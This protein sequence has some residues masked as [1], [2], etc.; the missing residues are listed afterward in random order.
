MPTSKR[1]DTIKPCQDDR[2]IKINPSYA[3]NNR[4]IAYK[5]KGETDHAIKDLIHRSIRRQL[6]KCFCQP[7]QCI[8][9]KGNLARA[10]RDY[11][12]A[13]RL[14][15]DDDTNR[16]DRQYWIHAISRKLQSALATVTKLFD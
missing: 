13:V 9:K 11:D 1:A 16:N 3:F 8:L 10:S 2:S 15:P 12:E 5:K 6:C 14:Q 7:G 4:G